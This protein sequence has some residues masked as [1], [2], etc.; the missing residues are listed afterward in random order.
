[1]LELEKCHI[2]SIGVTDVILRVYNLGSIMNMTA[3]F[4]YFI[5]NRAVGQ[6]SVD[7]LEDDEEVSEA[8]DNLINVLESRYSSTIGLIQ[9][10]EAPEN[11]PKGILDE[12]F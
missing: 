1:M 12:E 4:A 3:K 7:G 11:P 8:I 9:L 10:E 5:G 2:D 6:V